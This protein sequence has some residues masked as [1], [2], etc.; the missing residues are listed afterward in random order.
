MTGPLGELHDFYQPPPPAWTPQ[1]VG[2]YV[3]FTFVGLVAIGCVVR[4][5]RRWHADRYRREALRELSST[6]PD[7]LSA[8]L[9]RVALAAWPREKVAALNGENWLQF[10]GDTSKDLD[11]HQAPGNLI[12]E[13]ALHPASLSAQQ[14]AALR[15]IA[16]NWI[17][18][19]R[20]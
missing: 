18:R 20:V 17:R 10:L 6:P 8:L 4:T 5:I 9:K 12:E 11:F 2:W 3:L 1:T 15:E 19:H 7:Q 16:A 13:T 14:T